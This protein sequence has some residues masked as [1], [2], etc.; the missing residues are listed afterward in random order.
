MRQWQSSRLWLVTLSLHNSQ[1]MLLMQLLRVR[2]VRAR[3]AG[4]EQQQQPPAGNMTA[5]HKPLG[6]C[7]SLGDAM[8]QW[9]SRLAMAADSATPQQPG[10]AADAAAGG[11]DRSEAADA[12][13]Q[14]QPAA[15]EYEYVRDA[16]KRQRGE[17]Q[18]LAPATEEQARA[19]QVSRQMAPGHS[20]GHLQS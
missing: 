5:I 10:D 15:G 18:A 19:L 2:T 4:S 14:Q 9:R 7:R 11:E 16:D 12:E 17:T 1:A 3:G 13:Q 6:V 20:T 8:R